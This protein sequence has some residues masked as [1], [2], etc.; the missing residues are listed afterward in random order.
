MAK[1]TALPSLEIIRGYKGILDFYVRRGQPCVRKWP[2]TPRSRRTAGSNAAAALFGGILKSYRLVADTVLEAYQEN[3]KGIPRT[4]RDVYVSGVLGHL[5]ERTIPEPPPPPPEVFMTGPWLNPETLFYSSS[6]YAWK[7]NFAKPIRA[8]EIS[9]LGAK[10]DWPQGITLKFAVFTVAGG[11]ITAVIH[12]SAGV[13]LPPAL[14][15]NPSAARIWET[16]DP[17]WALDAGTLYLI[18]VGRTDGA[19]NYPLPV[20]YPATIHPPPFPAHEAV[21]GTGR[22]AKAN[23]LVGDPVNLAAG[24]ISLLATWSFT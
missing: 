20:A 21:N 22:V 12:E 13:T 8:L 5:H 17:P 6:A 18:S 23:P 10:G 14:D 24:T 19:N 2:H 7:G 15:V 1:L 16:F 9:A 4:P 11:V 3:A